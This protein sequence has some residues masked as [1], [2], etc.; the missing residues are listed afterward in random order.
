RCEGDFE[1]RVA[2]KLLGGPVADPVL[3]SM[4]QRERAML[5]QLEHPNI[6]RLIDG[7]ITA[8]R[9]PWFAMEYVDGQPVHEYANQHRLSIQD[10]LKLL[11]QA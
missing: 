10:R 11:L 4:F 3:V 1:Q 9:R 5:A 8:K 6:A 7:G 2:L